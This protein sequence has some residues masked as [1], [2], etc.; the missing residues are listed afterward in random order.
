MQTH[1]HG[2][3]DIFQRALFNQDRFPKK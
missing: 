2:A 1:A 3:D